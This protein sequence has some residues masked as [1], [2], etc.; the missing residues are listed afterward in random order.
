VDPTN[1]PK[2][3]I[4]CQG[5]G[6][7]TAF[8]AGVLSV[9]LAPGGTQRFDLV[10]LSG[11]S[12]GALCATL[13]W[14]ALV[15][16]RSDARQEAI[17]RLLAFWD[18]L[19]ASGPLEAAQNFWGLFAARL[20]FV[21]EISPYA[22]APFAESELRRLLAEHAGFARLPPKGAP[23]RRKPH[24]FV[25]AT[26]ILHGVTDENSVFRG[27]TLELDEVI[28]SAAVPP[29]FRAIE[30]RG[31]RYWDGLFS[32]NPPIRCFTDLP[33]DDMPDQIW[34]I[35]INP[36][37]RDSEPRS[38]PEIVDRRNELSGNLSLDQEVSFIAT[39]NKL[40]ARSAEVAALYKHI[41]VREIALTRPDLDYASKLDRSPAL[42]EGL[43]ED[44]RR[45]GAAFLA[46][47]AT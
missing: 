18:D 41:A 31:S 5:G 33:G 29:V 15:S 16:G 37:G 36:R 22:Y 27:D 32:H 45:A 12:G 19:K 3:A 6:S 24:L 10:G 28:A 14:S 42:I 7:H 30:A 26:D 21:A 4:A 44:G 1:K 11:T 35:R 40:R 43:I 8:T 34:I 39:I 13:A 17:R 2:I 9:L 25:G 20:P 38:V 47:P 23:E 46:R